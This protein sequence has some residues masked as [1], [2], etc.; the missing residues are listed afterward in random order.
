MNVTLNNKYS[1]YKN[2]QN[3]TQNNIKNNPQQNSIASNDKFSLQNSPDVSFTGNPLQSKATGILGG[4]KQKFVEGFDKT[5]D[6]LAENLYV[7]LADSKP[8]QWVS[9]KFKDSNLL[10]THMVAVGGALIGGIYMGKTINNK[11]MDEDRRTTL[12]INQGLALVGS[13]I[14]AYAL[15]SSLNKWWGKQTANYVGANL[16]DKNFVKN[17]EKELKEKKSAPKITELLDKSPMFDKVK[18]AELKN[19]I[20]GMSLFKSMLVFGT[21]YRFVV[22]VLVTPFANKIGEH[23]NDARHAKQAEK[24]A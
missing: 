3:K 9:E 10:Y 22:P 1:A 15:D 16:E 17:Y 21:V 2:N 12:A 4:V 19:R 8:V 20:N 5:T 14:G 11:N 7:T 24:S 13:T 18:H 6:W 23:V